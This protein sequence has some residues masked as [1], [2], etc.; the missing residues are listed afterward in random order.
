VRRGYLRIDVM[1]IGDNMT[2]VISKETLVA[3][4]AEDPLPI[5][6]IS[7]AIGKLLIER[8]EALKIS[9]NDALKKG[10]GS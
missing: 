7:D 9:R 10:N 8:N 6:K 5:L 2:A 1:W 4:L 3:N